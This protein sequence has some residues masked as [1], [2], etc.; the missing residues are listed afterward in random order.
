M[1]AT[2]AAGKKEA[3]SEALQGWLRSDGS[4][5]DAALALGSGG[6]ARTTDL[7]QELN[8][9]SR[10]SLHSALG[11]SLCVFMHQQAIFLGRLIY[12]LAK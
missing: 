6:V 2:L 9:S 3:A 11:P 1:Q 10:T 7:E 12:P 5:G 8:V 4:R